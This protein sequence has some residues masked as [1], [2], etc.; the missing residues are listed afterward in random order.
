MSHVSAILL[1]GVR[2]RETACLVYMYHMTECFVLH[3]DILYSSFCTKCPLIL[4]TITHMLQV[5]S[6]HAWLHII[7]DERIVR[8]E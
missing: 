5:T 1:I 3:G 4:E 2:Y 7:E 8:R 6:L